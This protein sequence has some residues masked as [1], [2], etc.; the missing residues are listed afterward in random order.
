MMGITYQNRG[1]YAV[2]L[3]FYGYHYICLVDVSDV[4]FSSDRQFMDQFTN[5]NDVS[6]IIGACAFPECSTTSG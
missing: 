4:Q 2:I 5:N 1:V 6:M 3:S